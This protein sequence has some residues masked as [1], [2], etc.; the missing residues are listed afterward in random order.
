MFHFLVTQEQAISIE[1]MF[2]LLVT[3]EQSTLNRYMFNL[4]VTHE[5]DPSQ[6]KNMVYVICDT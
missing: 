5:R 3:H 1:Y 2:H 4:L 6:Y